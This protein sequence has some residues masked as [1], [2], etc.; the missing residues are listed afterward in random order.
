[1]TSLN[2]CNLPHV[3]HESISV[4]IKT[5]SKI[6]TLIRRAPRLVVLQVVLDKLEIMSHYLN[7]LKKYTALKSMP[8]FER[9]PSGHLLTK[10]HRY[11]KCKTEQAA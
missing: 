8:V 9:K 10:P 11:K 3:L 5:F 1:M 4:D 7:V 2:V 6:R